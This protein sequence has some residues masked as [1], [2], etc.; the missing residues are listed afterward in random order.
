MFT[1]GAGQIARNTWRNP[2]A[3]KAIKGA[4]I[5]WGASVLSSPIEGD[6]SQ[7]GGM[8]GGAL[9]GAALGTFGRKPFGKSARSVYSRISSPLSRKVGYGQSNWLSRAYASP[10]SKY[11][12]KHMLRSNTTAAMYGMAGL[13]VGSAGL[14]G[15]S[16][17][18]S[19]KGYR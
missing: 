11:L 6:Q 4:G 12:G 3:R 2:I 7:F 8:L 15:S 13:G 5:G 19:N 9:A 18:S 1:W 14:I 16:V 17:L 10:Y